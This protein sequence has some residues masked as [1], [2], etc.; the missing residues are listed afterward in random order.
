MDEGLEVSLK[1]DGQSSLTLHLPQLGLTGVQIVCPNPTCL[2]TNQNQK[3]KKAGGE[4]ETSSSPPAKKGSTDAPIQIEKE[5]PA[6]FGVDKT[7]S[8]SPDLPMAQK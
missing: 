1:A 6:S 8:P 3:E 4:A 7:K 2:N 5:D